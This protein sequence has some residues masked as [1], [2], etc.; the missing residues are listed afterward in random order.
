VTEPLVPTGIF[1]IGAQI[2][3]SRVTNS[4]PAVPFSYFRP[5]TL[6]AA[7]KK[8]PIDDPPFLRARLPATSRTDRDDPAVSPHWSPAR[9]STPGGGSPLSGGALHQE[10]PCS[11]HPGSRSGEVR[12]LRQRGERREHVRTEQR[13]GHL[14]TPCPALRISNVWRGGGNSPSGRVR[15]PDST[16]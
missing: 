12:R 6:T 7:R 10:S 16:C 13:H 3:A 4:S 14:A 8:V 5:W 9:M 11:S 1:R 2:P 15:T